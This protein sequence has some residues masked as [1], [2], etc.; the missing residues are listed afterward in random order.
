MV[1]T[2]GIACVIHIIIID[3]FFLRYLGWKYDFGV[4]YIRHC[5]EL[6]GGRL[7]EANDCSEERISVTRNLLT[8]YPGRP[9]DAGSPGQQG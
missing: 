1:P 4:T 9:L 5:L 2:Q 7:R 8:L 3:D 6:G